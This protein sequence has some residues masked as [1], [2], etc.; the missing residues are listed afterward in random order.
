MKGFI[1]VGRATSGGVENGA[2]GNPFV[3]GRDG[4]VKACIAKYRAHLWEQ[5]KTGKVSMQ[6]LADLYGRKLF[7]P[8]CGVGAIT[9]H[10]RVLEDAAEWAVKQLAEES[11]KAEEGGEPEGGGDP[12]AEE[13]KRPEFRV[14]VAGSR[15]FFGPEAE[16]RMDAV[17]RKVLSQKM[18]TH[19]VIVVSG[20]AAGADT[21]GQFWA[22]C[23]RLKVERFKADWIGLGKSAG[24]K[25]NQQMADVADALI[26]FWD[27]KSPGTKHMIGIMKVAGKPVQ[28]FDF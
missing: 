6:K 25:R 27:G 13:P 14:I 1:N 10:A 21:L 11:P 24:F 16:A 22:N 5:I 28:V 7:C 4:D 17:L 20:C 8:G 15:N 12:K 18:V 3:V 23:N 19:D 26:A 2:W 9:C